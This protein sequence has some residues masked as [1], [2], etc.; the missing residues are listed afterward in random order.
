M[1]HCERSHHQRSYLYGWWL[2]STINRLWMRRQVHPTPLTH[3]NLPFNLHP[4]ITD[5]PV[6]LQDTF[7]HVL[8]W[9]TTEPCFWKCNWSLIVR[10]NFSSGM[11]TRLS[12]FQ[13]SFTAYARMRVL[14]RIYNWDE[15]ERAPM[16][17]CQRRICLCVCHGPACLRNFCACA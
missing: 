16:L 2:K 11:L 6:I 4:Q 15:R 9:R 7:K 12:F 1:V 13:H 8:I 17:W 3:S 10:L 5:H 14:A